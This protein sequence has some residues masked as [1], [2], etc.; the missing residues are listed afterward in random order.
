MGRDSLIRVSIRV[1]GCRDSATSASHRAKSYSNMVAIPPIT[2]SLSRTL[3]R[4]HPRPNW[5]VCRNGIALVMTKPRIVVLTTNEHDIALRLL[6]RERTPSIAADTGRSVH[7]IR[8][9][10]RTIYDKIGIRG[11]SQLADAV[12]RGELLLREVEQPPEAFGLGSAL[13]LLERE[14]SRATGERLRNV[15]LHA[16]EIRALENAG[17]AYHALANI[18]HDVSSLVPRLERLVASAE[19][20]LLTMAH[21]LGGLLGTQDAAA[22]RSRDAAEVDAIGSVL[23]DAP[24]AVEGSGRRALL[25]AFR[26]SYAA[27]YRSER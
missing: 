6:R 21:R 27:G 25:N 2:D 1:G 11:L 3:A 15:R 20:G 23:A 13:R 14:S 9:T 7:T 24:F 5:W 4:A 8:T 18:E 16:E 22:R 19:S 26:T 17:R 12:A 10:I